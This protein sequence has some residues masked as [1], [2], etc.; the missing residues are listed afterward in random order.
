MR[1][2]LCALALSL[3][4]SLAHAQTIGAHLGTAHWQPGLNNT[5]PGIYY[6]SEN[7]ITVGGY[8]NSY[9]KPTFYAGLTIQEG[10]FGLSLVGATGYKERTGWTITPILSP[11]YK[12]GYVR[13][14]LP[15]LQGV[16]LS[17]EGEF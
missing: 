13:L 11:S 12:L 17:V 4:S 16:H 10:N 6:V 7:G 9:R 3:L 15:N 8:Y 1:K 2:I 5:N 14:S